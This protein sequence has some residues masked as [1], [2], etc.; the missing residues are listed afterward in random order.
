M[1]MR[2]KPARGRRPAPRRKMARKSRPT[3]PV[4]VG[5]LRTVNNYQLRPQRVMKTSLSTISGNVMT[6]AG[7]PITVLGGALMGSMP[8]F[9]NLANLYN[10]YKMNKITYTFNVQATGNAT[11]YTYDL[12][13]I[14]VRY[15]YDSNLAS[16]NVQTRIQECNNFKQFQFT[17]EKTTFSYTYYPRCIEP[18]YLSLIASGYKLAK[19]QF[20]DVQYSSIPHYGIMWYVDNL[21]TGL[22][23]TYDITWDATFKYQN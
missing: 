17:P 9:A 1:P 19:P 8:D 10:R 18:V 3:G 15:N 20:I 13:K 12:P 5:Q 11:L 23:I 21:A 14:A 4:K 22:I 2:K 6:G 16:A 7:G